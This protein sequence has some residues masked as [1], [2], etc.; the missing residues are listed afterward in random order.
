MERAT[1]LCVSASEFFSYVGE[2]DWPGPSDIYDSIRVHA[3]GGIAVYVSR[4]PVHEELRHSHHQGKN[5]VDFKFHRN[6]NFGAPVRGVCLSRRFSPAMLAA[7][8]TNE[9]EESRPGAEAY[10]V[11][12]IWLDSLA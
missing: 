7:I 11:R 1:E 5:G 2:T 12:R 6:S 8:D 9:Y 10:V 3:S 4:L